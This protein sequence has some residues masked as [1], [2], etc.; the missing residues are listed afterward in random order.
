MYYLKKIIFVYCML[1]DKSH[2]YKMF[3]TN[4]CNNHKIKWNIIKNRNAWLKCFFCGDLNQTTLSERGRRSC[5]SKSK[6]ER[7]PDSPVLLLF[8]PKD[9]QKQ[10]ILVV[11]TIRDS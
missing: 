8:H 5:C 2:V 9:S 10:N 1:I 4:Q 7:F 6:K 3:N 11:K